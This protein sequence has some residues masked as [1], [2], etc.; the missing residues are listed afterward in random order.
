MKLFESKHSKS[1]ISPHVEVNKEEPLPFISCYR[2]GAKPEVYNMGNRYNTRVVLMAGGRGERFWPRSR[3][4][5]PKQFLDLEGKGSLLRTTFDRITKL[6]P[7]TNIYVATLARYRD[8]TL[9]ALPE[10]SEDHLIL[11]PVGRDTA[12]SL[13]LAA[14]WLH[15]EDPDTIMVALPADHMIDD[16]PQFL[17]TL[18]AA[19]A[20][21]ASGPYL[22]TLGISPTRPETGY[23][24]IRLGELH[25]Q[26]HG[27]SVFK[28][29][30]FVEKPSREVAEHYQRSG[31]YLWNAGMFVWQVGVLL[32]EIQLRMPE[33]HHVLHSLG[34]LGSRKAVAQALQDVFPTAPR[35][36]IDYGVM[37]RSDRVL[38]VPSHFGWDDLGSWASVERISPSNND[39]NIIR[40]NVLV[41]DAHG[42]I[43]D[44]VPNR[45][46]GL[47][48][49]RDLIVVDAEDALLICAKTHAQDV[50]KV[51]GQVD[52]RPAHLSTH[53]TNIYQ[54]AWGQE[55][56]LGSRTRVLEVSAGQRVRFDGM[57]AATL[58][59]QMGK[60]L[61]NSSQ[62]SVEVSPGEI[63]SRAPG[64]DYEFLAV[65]NTVLVMVT[66]GRH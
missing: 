41:H 54:R 7:A 30:R 35:L 50:K 21:A 63:V 8:L 28:A 23:G 36:S 22:V 18:E 3:P 47:V 2:W 61:L 17:A 46:I 34:A 1:V 32:E 25:D 45:L 52:D 60:G 44:G 10:L 29:Q 57:D 39:G 24:Y 9:R 6:I 66:A 4:D 65:T 42:V 40:G 43:V 19:I 62:A 48:G 27:F 55:V 11:E 49:V 64:L 13:G 31:D 58:Y 53:E 51:A 38:V 16:E 37:E 14:L 15:L 56:I 59:L 33:L 12:P 26:F 5:F 20:A